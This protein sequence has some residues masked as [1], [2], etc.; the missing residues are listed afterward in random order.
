M[1]REDT[2]LVIL[3]AI[4]AAFDRASMDKD[5]AKRSLLSGIRTALSDYEHAIRL[6]EAAKFHALL[7]ETRAERD[8][9]TGLYFVVKADNRGGNAGSRKQIY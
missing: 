7:D 3:D 5:A 4:D 2:L 9:M 8:R 6:N 1:S